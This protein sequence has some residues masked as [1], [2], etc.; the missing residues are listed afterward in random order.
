M[1]DYLLGLIYKYQN[2]GILVDTNVALL[3]L[4]G[5]CEIRLIR[6]TKRTAVYSE[7]DFEKVSKFIE[8]FQLKI[9]TPNVLTEIS[10][11]LPNRPEIASVLRQFI[12]GTSENYVA[13]PNLTNS[14]AFVEFGLADASIFETAKNK[15]LVF[16]DDGPLTGYLINMGVDVVQMDSVRAI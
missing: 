5:S 1:N 16:T 13:S 3:Y 12:K 6:E 14:T 8:K 7:K 10:N 9:T 4:V 11:L 15:Y 2:L